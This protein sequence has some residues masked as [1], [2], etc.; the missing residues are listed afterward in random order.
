VSIGNARGVERGAGGAL[1]ARLAVY[2]DLD[3]QVR[4]ECS[5]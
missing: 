3:G 5:S 4:E 2:L 1:E